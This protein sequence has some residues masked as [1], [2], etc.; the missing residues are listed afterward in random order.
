[1]QSQS[2]MLELPYLFPPQVLED[3]STALVV[4]SG[5]MDSYT[6]LMNILYAAR[7]IPKQRGTVP[8]RVEAVSFFYSQRHQR[9]LQ[10]ASAVCQAFQVKHSTLTLPVL[11]Q[12]AETSG[13][14]LL[15]PSVDVPHGHYAAESM[16]KT[17][18]PGRNTLMLATALAFAEGRWPDENVTV[19]YGAHS[20]DHAIYPDCRPE[21][22]ESMRQTMEEASDRRVSLRAPW[23]Y[24]TKGQILRVGQELRRLGERIDYG[25]TW[26]CY[27]GG[28]V[29]CGKCGACVERAEAFAFA[30][31]ADPLLA[32]RAE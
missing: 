27:E 3:G 21:F 5:G 16:K 12:L 24:R 31:E 30:G 9:E 10:V 1:M 4:F 8:K 7:T 17:V 25:L 29:P 6:L 32:V 11:S 22:V 15:S 26:T 13:S 23:L 20:G 18:V 2:S 28:E 19:F 14:A